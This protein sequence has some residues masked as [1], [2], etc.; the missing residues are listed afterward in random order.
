MALNGE[1]RCPRCGSPHLQVT[2]RGFDVGQAVAGRLLLGRNEGL[3][4]GAIGS[5]KP[6]LVCVECG[7]SF[8]AWDYGKELRKFKEKEAMKDPKE[9][10]RV[11]MVAL[12][13]MIVANLVLWLIFR[14][15]MFLA[16]L[17]TGGIILFVVLIFWI[18]FAINPPEEPQSKQ[19]LQE[20]K[21]KQ[22]QQKGKKGLKAEGQK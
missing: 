3:L 1:Y 11:Y 2:S 7:Y 4:A 17:A 16:M 5:N 13:S 8:Y 14:H 21:G 10:R 6:K 9:R 22:L 12:V 15:A 20:G 19:A 18:A